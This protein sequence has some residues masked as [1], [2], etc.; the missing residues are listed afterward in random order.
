MEKLEAMETRMSEN[1]KNLE[2]E[3]GQSIE[4]CHEGV[5]NILKKMEEQ[6]KRIDVFFKKVESQEREIGLLKA[7]N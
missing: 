2:T 6:E 4:F 1:M 7:K 3:L 5:A